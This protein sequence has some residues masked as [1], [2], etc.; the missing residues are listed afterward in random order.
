MRST[1][2]GGAAAAPGGPPGCTDGDGSDLGRAVE[3]GHLLEV[4]VEAPVVEVGRS[5]HGP[6]AVHDHRLRV[7]HP[8]G[9][10]PHPDPRLEQLPHVVLAAQ[11]D[12]PV[13]RGRPL[14]DDAH[15]DARAGGDRER[16]AHGQVGHHVRRHDPEAAAGAGERPQERLPHGVHV[17][18]GAPRHH[19]DHGVALGRRLGEVRPADGGG[20]G[21]E[22]PV[23]DEDAL[24]VQDRRALEAR[25][26]VVPRAA[27]PGAAQVL[28]P[29]V[30]PSEESHATVADHDLPVVAEVGGDRLPEGPQG[31]EGG[32]LPALAP[33]PPEQATEPA[34]SHR[35]D[36][37]PHLDARPAPLDQEVD[38]TAAELVV[39][40]DVELDVH[41]VLGRA[42]RV[43]HG[44]EGLRAVPVE[45]HGVPTPCGG[46]AETDQEA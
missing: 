19:L 28:P 3:D 6:L 38:R 34:R 23:L 17:L 44:E 14:G 12:H 33:Q 29:H 36:E 21:R 11:L 26:E 2:R 31:Q 1:G 7:H 41:V 13:V 45:G 24:Q 8:L 30:E 18:V 46:L 25:V 10:A 22:V 4:E 42:D 39:A 20:A 5:H 35:V 27:A 32:G 16:V 37:G 43:L 15:V 9:V 40:E